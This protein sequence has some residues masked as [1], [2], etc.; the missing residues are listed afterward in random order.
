MWFRKADKDTILEEKVTFNRALNIT[1]FE[2]ILDL[3]AKPL[4]AYDKQADYMFDR[5]NNG[6]S[7]IIDLQTKINMY[8]FKW[9]FH[10]SRVVEKLAHEILTED[11]INPL[12]CTIKANEMRY[13]LLQKQYVDL[14]TE[15]KRKMNEKDRNT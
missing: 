7:L 12:L 4:S 9:Q 15:F 13:N 11:L 2:G 8:P 14:E 6:K 3:L 5:L 1:N 10:L